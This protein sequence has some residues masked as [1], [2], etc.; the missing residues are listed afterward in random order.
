MIKIMKN[1][2]FINIIKSYFCFKDKK[3]KLIN[4]CNDI[5]NKDICIERILKRL[6][7]L[8]KEYNL[9][10]EKDTNKSFINNDIS[11]IK[12]IIKKINNETSKQI[13][14]K[15]ENMFEKN[16]IIKK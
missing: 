11:K 9:L 12:N 16:N 6:Y 7:I 15:Y 10:I 13:Q 14:N 1:L 8:E 4:F 3:L 5:V 2:N